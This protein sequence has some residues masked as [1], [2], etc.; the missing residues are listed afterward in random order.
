MSLIN[1]VDGILKLSSQYWQVCVFHTA[2]KHKIF[3]NL[4]R[5]QQTP[6]ELAGKINTDCRA[7]ELLLNALVSLGLLQK[8][9]DH[10]QNSSISVQYLDE[11]SP[12]FIGHI[13]FHMIDMY[14]DWGRLDQAIRSGDPL[15][16]TKEW[17]E[18]A[19]K[20]FLLG[21]HNIAIRGADT[22][23]Q[24]LNFEGCESLLDLGG[25]P[26]TYAIYFCLRN[27]GLKAIVFDLP[28]TKEVA[29]E[30]ISQYGL[31]GYIQFEG[32]D[33]HRDDIPQGPFDRVFL[34]HIL[35]AQTEEECLS[36]INKIYP[37]LKEGGKIIVQDFI[38][39]PD[40]TWPVFPALF[41]LNML[42]YTPGGRSYSSDEIAGWLQTV[43]FKDIQHLS[44]P[45]PYEA[46]VITAKKIARVTR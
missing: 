8:R 17:D 16:S 33:F 46:S 12:D 11:N 30:K 3:T 1:S 37:V 45:L 27:P 19:R 7:T 26:G 21:M 38:L 24:K 44:F 31:E 13:I 6:K 23:S 29:E 10:F 2:M 32:G 39:H 43:G 9:G 5:D 34:S 4:G 20:N 22:L 25:G 41:A 36:L 40:R 15:K 14:P 18:K 35:H 42:I 28:S